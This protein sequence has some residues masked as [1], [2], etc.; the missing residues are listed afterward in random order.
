MPGPAETPLNL[1]AMGE[2]ICESD[3][4]GD[5]A[6]ERESP[7]L[8][9]NPSTRFSLDTLLSISKQSSNGE[10]YIAQRLD[11]F[12]MKYE[13]MLE[14]LQIAQNRIETSS[15]YAE[16]QQRSEVFLFYRRK[17]HLLRQSIVQ[18]NARIRHIQQRLNKVRRQ[19]PSQHS[20]VE[21]GPFYYRCVYPGGV[22]YRDYPSSLASVIRESLVVEYDQVVEVVERVFIA[23]EYSV[24]LHIRGIGWLFENIKDMVCFERVAT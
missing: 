22:R 21:T 19:I 11:I 14:S 1:P 24:F 6:T 5:G 9:G 8:S 10:A 2:A 15:H 3:N 13:Q 16:A 23:Q 18:I 20:L 12:R 17:L 4:D 7:S